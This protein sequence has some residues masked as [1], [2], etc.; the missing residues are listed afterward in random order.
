MAQ[1]SRAKK[2]CSFDPFAV[3]VKTLKR[4]RFEFAFVVSGS[5][6]RMSKVKIVSRPMFLASINESQ[7]SELSIR[8][9]RNWRNIS[10]SSSP[11]ESAFVAAMIGFQ[12]SL[13]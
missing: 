9:S 6:L 7:S 4:M 11:P 5:V 13:S 2:F 8:F 12:P 3:R 10:T 1:T